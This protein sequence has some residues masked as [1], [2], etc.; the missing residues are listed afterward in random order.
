MFLPLLLFDR[1]GTHLPKVIV[2]SAAMFLTNVFLI[3][4]M[5]QR[6]T[7]PSVSSPKADSQIIN[8]QEAELFQFDNKLLAK[9]FGWIGLGVGTGAL[10]WFCFARPE[11]GSVAERGAY[12]LSKLKSDRVTI[13]FCADLLLFWIFQSWLMGAAMHKKSPLR[14]VPFWGLAIW[15]ISQAG[16]AAPKNA[17]KG[18]AENA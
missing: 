9:I 10:L 1:R 17:T 15:L 13:A 7:Q 14:F 5:A 2:W 16:N 18:A 4:Y 8:S 11:F 3:P 12:L 6:L